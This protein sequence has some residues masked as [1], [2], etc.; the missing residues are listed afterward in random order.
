MWY[1]YRQQH[2]FLTESVQLSHL[3]CITSLGK[4]FLTQ[5]TLCM[6]H[7]REQVEHKEYSSYQSCSHSSTKQCDWCT[8]LGYFPKYTPSCQMQL[9]NQERRARSYINT[10]HLCDELC[11]DCCVWVIR[12]GLTAAAV[13]MM[14]GDEVSDTFWERTGSGKEEVFREVKREMLRSYWWQRKELWKRKRGDEWP[15][16]IRNDQCERGNWGEM[17]YLRMTQWE[18]V[19]MHYDLWPHRLGRETNRGERSLDCLTDPII[20]P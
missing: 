16:M 15:R 3:H 12:K 4:H 17:F 19:G 10:Q 2:C 5:V 8:S 18:K 9:A 1:K 20:L 11:S 6:R 7:L 13:S 14:N